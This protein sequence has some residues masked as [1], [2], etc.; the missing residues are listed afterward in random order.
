MF[1]L[2][3]V[4]EMAVCPTAIRAKP[5]GSSGHAPRASITRPPTIEVTALQAIAGKMS[6]PQQVRSCRCAPQN[7]A[8]KQT[9]IENVVIIDTTTSRH[10]RPKANARHGTH[11]KHRMFE[12]KLTG[13]K[14]AEQHN[15]GEKRHDTGNQIGREL[16]HGIHKCRN[17]GREQNNRQNIKRGVRAL[18][19][20][21]EQALTPAAATA[22]PPTSGTTN[23][24]L[25]P[26]NVHIR[27]LITGPNAGPSV[28]QAPPELRYRPSF[29]RGA[30]D[31]TIHH[32]RKQ[33]A[34]SRS[35]QNTAWQQN[36]KR[37]S[38]PAQDFAGDHAFACEKTAAC[39][40]RNDRTGRP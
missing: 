23:T 40:S 35:L 8:A 21:P 9:L 29:S 24:A 32:E 10:S 39:A 25:Q 5:T 18:S 17:A 33:D 38:D 12:L 14:Q 4:I 15:G 20:I 1:M 37:R 30:Q 27:P 6:S 19:D 34:R 28:M 13:R 16:A 22:M 3:A 7:R 11:V 26:N 2:A 36:A 31:S